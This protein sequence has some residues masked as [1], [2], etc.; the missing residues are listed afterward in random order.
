MKFL[1]LNFFITLWLL[2][3]M[4]FSYSVD[5]QELGNIVIH[6]NPVKYYNVVFKDINNQ[7]IKLDKFENKLIIL[8]FWATWCVPC[9][10]EMPYLDLLQ[11]NNNLSNIKIFPI[12]ISQEGKEKQKKFFSQLNIKNL[13]IFIDSY[14]NLVKKFMLRGIPT[15]ILIN[16]QGE[17]F[18]RIVGIYNFNDTKFIEWLKNY[19]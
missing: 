7:D 9:R 4:S 2:L 6:K 18:A 16:K 10:E 17:E 15:T 1:T 13:E 3:T 14:G 19:N 11:I 12:N 5:N 8:N